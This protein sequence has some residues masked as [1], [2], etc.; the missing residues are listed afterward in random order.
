MGQIHLVRAENLSCPLFE[1]IHEGRKVTVGRSTQKRIMRV[2][3]NGKFY[4]K[5]GTKKK[6]DRIRYLSS[7]GTW[8]ILDDVAQVT[9]EPKKK[10]KK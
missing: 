1:A 10:A 3:K 8:V 5:W 9:S 4:V 2:T 7:G 6:P